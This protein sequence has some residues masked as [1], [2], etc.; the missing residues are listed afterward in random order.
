MMYQ[1]VP[2]FLLGKLFGRQNFSL[3]YLFIYLF[4][5]FRSML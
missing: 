3:S 2:V 4:I 5:Y 1:K